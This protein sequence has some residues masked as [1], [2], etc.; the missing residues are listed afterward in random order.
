MKILPLLFVP[1]FLASCASAP[2]PAQRDAESAKLLSSAVQ[3]VEAEPKGTSSASAKPRAAEMAGGSI[4]ISFAG[5]A[6]DLLRQV[7]ASRSMSFRVQ[8]P[9]PH[10][11][12][13]TIV[14]VQGVTLEAFLTDVGAQ[15]GQRADLALT[16]DSIEVRYRD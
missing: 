2:E 7:A 6:K 10:L 3:R 13:F 16:N 14:D 11:P 1:I 9:Q 4:T 12:L 8:G 5:D 15:F